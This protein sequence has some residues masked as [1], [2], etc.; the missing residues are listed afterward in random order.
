[1]SLGWSTESA[2][3]PGKEREI[4]VPS[5]SMVGLR[6]QLAAKQEEAASG[7]RKSR[8]KRRDG[9]EELDEFGRVKRNRG[10]ERRAAADKAKAEEN[11]AT[12]MLAAKAQ[13]YEELSSG[14]K[15]ARAEELLVDF[16]GK[17]PVAPNVADA[18]HG[19]GTQWAWGT[20][21][22]EVDE[23]DVA[24]MLAQTAR[25][26]AAESRARATLVSPWEQRLTTAQ[27]GALDAVASE[28]TEGRRQAERRAAERD[29]RRRA[30][31][32]RLGRGVPAEP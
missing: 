18:D 17:H 11:L 6:A 19:A 14:T 29:E 28:T 5:S 7:R 1:M 26:S 15:R 4:N 8:G 16:G 30:L 20:G 12:E 25:N 23:D 9:G 22:P 2:L 32:A 13:L 24:K 27:R 21:R 10:V 3:L 31:A